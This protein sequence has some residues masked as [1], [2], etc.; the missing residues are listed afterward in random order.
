VNISNTVADTATV[1]RKSL[2]AFHWHQH[3]WPWTAV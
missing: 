3:R 1:N 2:W